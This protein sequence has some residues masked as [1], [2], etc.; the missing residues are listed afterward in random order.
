MHNCIEFKTDINLIAL[1]HHEPELE[2]LYS[3]YCLIGCFVSG[4]PIDRFTRKCQSCFELAVAVAQTDATLTLLFKTHRLE[5]SADIDYPLQLGQAHA[6]EIV[7]I[8]S[9]PVCKRLQQV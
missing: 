4:N 3:E 9:K 6:C 1:D 5:V 8:R 2:T 7:Y